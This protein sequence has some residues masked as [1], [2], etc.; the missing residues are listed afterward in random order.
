M[1]LVKEGKKWVL[2]ECK[3]WKKTRYPRQQTT[4]LYSSL[5]KQ[6]VLDY[7]KEKF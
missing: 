4:I 2:K 3:A 7:I 6:N 5:T 1:K